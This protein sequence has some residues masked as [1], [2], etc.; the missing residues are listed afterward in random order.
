MTDGCHAQVRADSCADA[1]LAQPL[2]R[3]YSASLGDHFYTINLDEYSAANA[4]GATP[5]GTAARVFT[6]KVASSAQFFRLYSIAAGDHLY[7]TDTT[8][9]ATA[10]S[11][12]YN[13]T[14]QSGAPMYIYPSALCGTVPFYRLHSAINRD[15]FYTTNASE[16]DSAMA[17]GYA[18]EFIAGYVFDASSASSLSAAPLSTSTAASA[19]AATTDSTCVDLSIFL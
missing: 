3:D 7:T 10:I 14:L 18:F 13:Y 9:V 11:V 16:K 6:A 17:G 2:Y 19:S 15:H 5:E 1:S 8:E 12:K 4:A